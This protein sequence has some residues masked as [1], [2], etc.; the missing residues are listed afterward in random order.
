MSYEVLQL[1]RGLHPDEARHWALEACCGGSLEAERIPIRL[2]R[3]DQLDD[4]LRAWRVPSA[5]ANE[6]DINASIDSEGVWISPGCQIAVRR[7]GW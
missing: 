4:V 1:P 7:A 2:S 3:I 6:G 5:K